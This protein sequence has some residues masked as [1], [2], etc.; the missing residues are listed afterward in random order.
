MV[1]LLKTLL[2]VLTF[3]KPCFAV[4]I[5]DLCEVFFVVVVAD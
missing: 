2:Q 1:H 5:W 4:F 3:T